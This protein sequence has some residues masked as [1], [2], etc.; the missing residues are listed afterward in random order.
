MANK[1]VRVVDVQDL[2]IG[3]YLIHDDKYVEEIA[4]RANYMI[5][6]CSYTRGSYPESS[7]FFDYGDMIDIRR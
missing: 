7:L 3:D 5:L 1:N 4:Y 6:R 2:E